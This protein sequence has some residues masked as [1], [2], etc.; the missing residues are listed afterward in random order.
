MIR[1]LLAGALCVTLACWGS[2][3]P[4]RAA[5]MAEQLGL[6]GEGQTVVVID[7]G[8]AYNHLSLSGQFVGGWDFT[9]DDFDPFDDPSILNGHGSKVAGILAADHDVYPGIA[10]G[11]DIIS[12][13]V[14]DDNGQVFLSRVEQALDWVIDNRTTFEHPITT[15]NLSMSSNWNDNVPPIWGPFE[16]ELQEL[17]QVGV[18]VAVSAGNS[19]PE[20]GEPGLNYPAASPHVVPVMSIDSNGQLSEFS[21]RHPRAIAARGSALLSTIPDHLG[22]KNGVGD[23]WGAAFGTSFAAPQVAGA[24]MLIREAMQN[25]GITNINRQMIFDHMLATSNEFFDA[26]TQQTYRSIDLDAALLALADTIP[27]DVNGDGAVDA[28]DYATWREGLGAQFSSADYG[29]WQENFGQDLSNS[30]GNTPG[31]FDGNGSI[32]AVDYAVWR[33]G[34]G[35]RY[36]LGD[37]A[38]WRAG[39]GATSEGSGSI[40]ADALQG[41]PEPVSGLLMFASFAWLACQSRRAT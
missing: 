3:S 9:E 2:A 7:S 40:A 41:V 30:S 36:N 6:S 31:D 11:A 25:L 32:D 34:L 4:S 1:T 35:T 15:V 13:R 24:S 28:V 33:E 37:F 39:F 29:V 23:D 5:T 8:I 21:Q 20:F 17:E 38:V 26:A 22:N 12:L 14:Y 18:F 16:H 10:P 19:F 27:G